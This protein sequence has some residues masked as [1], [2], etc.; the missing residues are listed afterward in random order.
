MT[1]PRIINILTNS[2]LDTD[3]IS[4]KIIIDSLKYQIGYVVPPSDPVVIPEPEPEPVPEPFVFPKDSNISIFKEKRRLNV[5]LPSVNEL[6]GNL[7]YSKLN[8]NQGIFAFFKIY[9]KYGLSLSYVNLPNID[10]VDVKYDPT[11]HKLSLE[12]FHTIVL[13]NNRYII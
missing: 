8:E 11:Q 9:F 5:V 1:K 13:D 6:S 3:I 12:E 4:N 10:G 2:N 7:E